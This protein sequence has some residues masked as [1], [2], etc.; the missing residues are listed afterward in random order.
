MCRSDAAPAHDPERGWAVLV[1]GL[2]AM[3]A[4]R[5]QASAGQPDHS[6]QAAAPPG[7]EEGKHPRNAAHV[8][9]LDELGLAFEAWRALYHPAMGL[10]K[11]IAPSGAASQ[12]ALLHSH[13][14]YNSGRFV[15]FVK[16]L[17][18]V[19][20][21]LYHNSRAAALAA[22]CRGHGRHRHDLRL[23]VFRY[24]RAVPARPRRAAG[25]RSARTSPGSL[26]GRS[27]RSRG[28]DP[29]GCRRKSRTRR[30]W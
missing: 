1:S 21:L 3:P 28:P 9:D 12:T 8:A 17:V 22:L 10:S 5:G 7:R 6:R 15:H 20:G 16:I 18:I 2:A 13:I 4:H 14:H 19:V 24:Q 30:A 11:T 26:A 25:R 29:D 27:W 23:A